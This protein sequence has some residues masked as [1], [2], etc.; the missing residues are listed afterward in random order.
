MEPMGATVQLTLNKDVSVD[1]RHPKFHVRA[2]VD[3]LD[4]T[5]SELQYSNMLA[6]VSSISIAQVN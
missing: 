5:L 1:Y 4:L 2:Q 6:A 3:R